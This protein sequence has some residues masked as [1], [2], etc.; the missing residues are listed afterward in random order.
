V[1]F[2][3]LLLPIMLAMM[4]FVLWHTAWTRSLNLTIG[5]ALLLAGLLVVVLY[6]PWK[7]WKSPRIP[8]NKWK[9]SDRLEHE[10]K[11]RLGMINRKID[12]LRATSGDSER[13]T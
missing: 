3:R 11:Q 13:S 1:Y 10:G 7:F 8:A 4:L 5:S 9:F 2:Q 6:T 12:E